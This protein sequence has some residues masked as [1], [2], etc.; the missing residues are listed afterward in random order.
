MTLT[1][2]LTGYAIRVLSEGEELSNVGRDSE[3]IATTYYDST[4]SLYRRGDPIPGG[5]SVQLIDRTTDAVLA[6]TFIDTDPYD[7]LRH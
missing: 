6:E 2:T 4:V 3:P 1:T 5:V 7:G